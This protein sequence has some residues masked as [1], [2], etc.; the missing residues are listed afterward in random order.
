[1]YNVKLSLSST[2]IWWNFQV[3]TITPIWDIKK[4][5][6]RFCRKPIFH[7]ISVFFVCFFSIIKKSNTIFRKMTSQTHFYYRI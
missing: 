5:I 1:M 7:Y 2:S 4:N 6:D 3:S